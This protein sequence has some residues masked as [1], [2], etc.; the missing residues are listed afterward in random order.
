[1]DFEIG[2]GKAMIFFLSHGGLLSIFF[3]SSNHTVKGT[4]EVRA[5]CT[6]GLGGAYICMRI[7]CGYFDTLYAYIYICMGRNP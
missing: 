6:L 1:M 5:T 2:W 7:L 4:F 3:I